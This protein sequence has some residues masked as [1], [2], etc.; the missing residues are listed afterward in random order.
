MK[1]LLIAALALAGCTATSEPTGLALA[2][3]HAGVEDDASFS[4]KCGQYN[5]CTFTGKQNGTWRFSDWAAWGDAAVGSGI[6]FSRPM[7]THDPVTFET[8]YTTQVIHVVGVAAD[9]GYVRCDGNWS[10]HGSMC[11]KVNR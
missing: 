1:R 6:S 5:Y 11:R 10:P 9:T 4:I 8:P 2:A 7:S 3:N